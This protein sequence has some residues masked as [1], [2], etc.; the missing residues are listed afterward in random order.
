MSM[1]NARVASSIATHTQAMTTSEEQEL[2]CPDVSREAS[3]P[4][5]DPRRRSFDVP[6]QLQVI[7]RVTSRMR[8]VIFTDQYTL[9]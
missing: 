4:A 6:S 8:P 7:D 5:V 9:P 3:E 2:A 1:P